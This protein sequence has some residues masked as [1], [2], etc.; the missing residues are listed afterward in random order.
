MARVRRRRHAWLLAL[1]AAA[2]AVAVVVAVQLS[3]TDRHGARIVDF[4]VKS[5]LVGRRLHEQA[6]V[7]AG[8]HDGERRPLLVWLHGRSGHAGDFFSDELYAELARLGDRAPVVVELSGGDHSYWH[9]RRSGRWGAYVMRE[10]LPAALRRLPVDPRR[11]AIGG[12]SMGGFGALDLARANPGRFCAAGGHSPAIWTVA[13][14]T[15]PGAFDDADDF[16]RHDLVAY[17]RAT[18]RAF[19]GL[20]LWIDRGDSDPFVPGDAALVS[21]LRASGA[22]VTSRIWPG[23][24]DSDYWRAHTASYLR[25]YARAL[26]HCRR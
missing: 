15:A 6:V 7:P 16:A 23:E 14:E 2:A 21:A 24:H 13:G 8:L 4:T 1:V 20:P 19:G 10:A 22:T 9:D 17:A 12:V 5:R 25:F 18:P 26:A 11:V 3:G